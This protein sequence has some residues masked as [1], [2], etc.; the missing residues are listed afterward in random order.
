MSG[1]RF[2]LWTGLVAAMNELVRSGNANATFLLDALGEVIHA[3]GD[4]ATQVLYPPPPSALSRGWTSV[5]S[6]SGDL[7]VFVALPRGAV[8]CGVFAA[9]HDVEQA[10]AALE[11]TIAAGTDEQ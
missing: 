1:D 8:L 6:G 11:Q 2:E 9:T 10:R 4:F 7:L 5:R 3:R